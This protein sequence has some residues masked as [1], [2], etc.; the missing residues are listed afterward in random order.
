VLGLR[1]GRPELLAP[2]GEVGADDV[3]GLYR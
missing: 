1:G 2:A 3:R